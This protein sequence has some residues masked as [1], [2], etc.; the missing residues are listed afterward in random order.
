MTTGLAIMVGTGLAGW[1]AGA[2]LIAY[3]LFVLFR[4]VW[5]ED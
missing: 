5:R 2:L 1:A 4:I 3:F